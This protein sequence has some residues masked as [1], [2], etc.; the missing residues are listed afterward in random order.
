[1]NFDCAPKSLTEV[2]NASKT[3]ILPLN[4]MVS[5][6]LSCIDALHVLFGQIW[7]LKRLLTVLSIAVQ[8]LSLQVRTHRLHV[9]WPVKKVKGQWEGTMQAYVFI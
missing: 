3:K 9:T 5:Y 4:L 6:L 7:A 1:M 8:D 2:T